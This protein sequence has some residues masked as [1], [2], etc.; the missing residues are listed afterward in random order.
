MA[1]RRL[2]D[3][4]D[5]RHPVGPERAWNESR[6]RLASLFVAAIPSAMMGQQTTGHL[7]EAEERGPARHGP[8][9]AR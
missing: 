7:G 8:Q 6:Y 9:R 3:A 4:D 5:Y 2:S 1:D